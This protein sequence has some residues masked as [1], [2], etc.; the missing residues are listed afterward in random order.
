MKVQIVR[1]LQGGF[2]AIQTKIRSGKT[3]TAIIGYNLDSPYMVKRKYSA[4]KIDRTLDAEEAVKVLQSNMEK[5]H[6]IGEHFPNNNVGKKTV[7]SVLKSL[8]E[9]MG[10]TYIACNKTVAKEIVQQVDKNKRLHAGIRRRQE[11]GESQDMTAA[12]AAV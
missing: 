10:V 5:S 12:L 2:V 11:L 8:C 6:Y 9:K 1:L 7:T 4:A 3:L